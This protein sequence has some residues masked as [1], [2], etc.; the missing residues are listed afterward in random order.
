MGLAQG[1]DFFRRGFSK[2]T[3]NT[4]A[5]VKEKEK[6]VIEGITTLATLKHTLS[7]I[8]AGDLTVEHPASLGTNPTTL[9]EK[10][11]DILELTQEGVVDD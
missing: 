7:D 1:L 3:E 4:P 10:T 9:L 5:A 2:K 8:Y 6:P 11:L